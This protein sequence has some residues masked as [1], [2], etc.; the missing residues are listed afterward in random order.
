MA[1]HYLENKLRSR[2]M[3]TEERMYFKAMIPGALLM[4]IGT[5]AMVALSR[6]VGSSELAAAM[7]STWRWIPAGIAAWGFVSI[8]W[9]V[10]RVYQALNGEGY[11]CPTC[12]GPL[13]GEI[14]GRYGPYR[15][16]MNCRSN[17]SRRNYEPL[18]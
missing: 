2:R 10:F 17:V 16:C 12:E 9:R 5:V 15:K 18:E 6:A 1:D 14:D 11:L 3:T 13:G 4:V 8:G 7:F